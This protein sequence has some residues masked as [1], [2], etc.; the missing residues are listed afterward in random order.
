M[1]GRAKIGNPN[2]NAMVHYVRKYNI[3]HAFIVVLQIGWDI[4]LFWFCTAVITLEYRMLYF[5]FKKIQG[6]NFQT[7]ETRLDWDTLSEAEWSL[8]DPTRFHYF[9]VTV[10]VTVLIYS[11]SSCRRI[12]K[13]SE[14]WMAEK[15]WNLCCLLLSMLFLTRM[16]SLLSRQ[17]DNRYLSPSNSDSCVFFLNHSSFMVKVLYRVS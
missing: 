14:I 15:T 8:E 5:Y 17:I 16:S 10:H 2:N 6:K 9:D 12:L 4:D 13:I 7:T 3:V 1:R 11:E